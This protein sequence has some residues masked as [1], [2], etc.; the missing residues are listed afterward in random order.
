MRLLKC[1]PYSASVICSSS[2]LSL[3]Q[4]EIVVSPTQPVLRFLTP[5][6]VQTE[7][8]EAFSYSASVIVVCSQFVVAGCEIAE[9]Y[10]LLSQ[11]YTLS[12]LSLLL[13]VM[14]VLKCISYS[15]SYS[16]SLLTGCCENCAVSAS[17]F[18]GR[19]DLGAPPGKLPIYICLLSSY[20]I[21]VVVNLNSAFV[22][23]LCSPLCWSLRLNNG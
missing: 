14:R 11:C 17:A 15:A 8:V 20:C 9:V 12:L 10:L 21:H 6:F 13:Q 1:I 2:L 7:I 4:T 5:Q 18:I 23:Q 19:E 22:M 3:L 16:F